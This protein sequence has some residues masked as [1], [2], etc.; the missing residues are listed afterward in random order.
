LNQSFPGSL[1]ARRVGDRAARAADVRAEEFG[2][3]VS[4]KNKGSYE[5]MPGEM[6][7]KLIW[8]PLVPWERQRPLSFKTVPENK[9]AAS[10]QK[11]G[12]HDHQL[13]KDF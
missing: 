8:G 10:R 4:N 5:P 12:S 7:G 1:L 13:F 9:K 2:L 11:G 3:S 6:P